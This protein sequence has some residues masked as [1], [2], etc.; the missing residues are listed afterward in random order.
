MPAERE[1]ETG[2]DVVRADSAFVISPI[3]LEDSPERRHA[4]WVLK[5]IIQPACDLA[6]GLRAD[7]GEQITKSGEIM[8]QVID[9]ITKDR[10][11]IA[12][13]AFERPNV[14]YELALAMAAGR[15]VV[16]LRHSGE[17]RHFDIAGF[18]TVDYT[19]GMEGQLL[20][21]KV[22]ELAE[23]LRTALGQASHKPTV[24]GNRDP[25]GR[26][27]REYEFKDTFK[28]IDTPDYLEV[29]R[30]ASKFIGLQGI[31][32]FHFTKSSFTWNA[33]DHSTW[34]FFQVVEGKILFDAVDVIVVLMDENNSSLPH[35][36]KFNN[37]GDFTRS[38]KEVKAEIRQSYE[39]WSDLKSELEGRRSEREDGRKGSLKIHRL[40]HGV[41]NYR[42]T[43]TEQQAILTPYMNIFPYNSR[44]P[45]LICREGTTFYDR[46]YREFIDRAVSNE[47]ATAA[48]R[49][50]G[51]L[52]VNQ[53]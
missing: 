52:V 5:S 14:Y 20:S 49:E 46:L 11:V 50:H 37:R 42:L 21:D 17:K 8:D 40:V 48:I 45:A 22:A 1:S 26:L 7:R 30:K 33:H 39:A 38:L 4:D 34:T 6:G 51:S 28:E 18:R 31:S 29:F 25:L 27:Y 47:M 35:F 44:P 12:V 36:L 16:I 9:S 2:T 23:H 3:G 19:D 53:K 43:L 10:L 24:F 15:H 41:V 13:L 32:L